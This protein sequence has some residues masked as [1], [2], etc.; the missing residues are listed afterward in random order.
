MTGSRVM[1]LSNRLGECGTLVH[2]IISGT[3]PDL[4]AYIEG[5]EDEATIHDA[6]SQI[7]LANVVLEHIEK[8]IDEIANLI[9]QLDKDE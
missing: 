8:E 4:C 2:G 7:H 6:G 5:T 1:D 3:I 9:M